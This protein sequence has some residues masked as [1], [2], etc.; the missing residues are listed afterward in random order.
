MTLASRENCREIAVATFIPSCDLQSGG[1][2]VK[3]PAIRAR[4]IRTAFFPSEKDIDIASSSPLLVSKIE[5]GQG[6]TNLQVELAD[7]VLE[8]CSEEECS[9]S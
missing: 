2:R 9:E 8:E 3:C 6:C 7:T 1:I 5:V 4:R